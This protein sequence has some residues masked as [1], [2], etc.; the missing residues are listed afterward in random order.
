[1]SFGRVSEL[2]NFVTDIAE[3]SANILDQEND[4]KAQLR[5]ITASRADRAKKTLEDMYSQGAQSTKG[6]YKKFSSL[7]E[8]R[9]QVRIWL[10]SENLADKSVLQLQ[11]VTSDAVNNI[12][13]KIILA[14][15]S[16]SVPAEIE[17][18]SDSAST[19]VVGVVWEKKR[20]ST[21]TG[22]SMSATARRLFLGTS[23]PVEPMPTISTVDE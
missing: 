4:K 10:L 21:V 17:Q 16:P 20:R 5:K 12:S 18:D 22:Y 11:T 15:P 14:E 3:A 19:H 6:W 1:M 23:E 2:E 13:K 8:A 9:T 7:R